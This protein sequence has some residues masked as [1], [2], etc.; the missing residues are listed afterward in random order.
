MR[1]AHQEA[2]EKQRFAR[3]DSNKD[4]LLSLDETKSRS[5]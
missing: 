1:K 2:R 3:L 4:G 5:W